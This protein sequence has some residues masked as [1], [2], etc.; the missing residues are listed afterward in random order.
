MLLPR[1]RPLLWYTINAILCQIYD[2]LTRYDGLKIWYVNMLWS[3]LQ[4]IKRW[5]ARRTLFF[6]LS[7]PSS[8]HPQW[9]WHCRCLTDLEH[10]H[11]YRYFLLPPVG[12]RCFIKRSDW[13][14]GSHCFF[15]ISDSPGPMQSW[16]RSWPSSK[17]QSRFSPRVWMTLQC[18][19]L[20]AVFP[21]QIFATL[22]HS[23][24]VEHWVL[25]LWFHLRPWWALRDLWSSEVSLYGCRWV[26][27]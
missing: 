3:D 16:L 2:M 18:P 12:R 22:W 21:V 20:E 17:S 10:N 14:Q 15:Y 5:C 6:V 23:P 13:V 8:I 4:F 11:G 1:Q 19:G 24:L 7:E 9:F 26:I 27:N 25:I